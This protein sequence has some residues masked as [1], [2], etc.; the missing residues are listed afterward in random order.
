MN[1]TKTTR[2]YIN[3]H[4]FIK[5]CLT[6]RIINFSELARQII[7]DTKL[8]KPDFNAILVAARRYSDELIKHRVSGQ[9]AKICEL[10]KKCKLKVNTKICRLIVRKGIELNYKN[11]L[12]SIHGENAITI[13]AESEYY[14][15]LKSKY[16]HALLDK[17]NN[18]AELA[19]IS[20]KDADITQGFT[21]YLSSL[22]ADK[23]INILTTLGSYTDDIFIINRKDISVALDVLNE[24]LI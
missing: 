23:G 10:L 11:V 16:K 3:Q 4:L 15:E 5:H 9:E 19:I 13:I 18:L 7:T 2:Q 14:Q 24:V 22:L 6:K 17:K 21:S 1:I 12:H 8:R 20:P